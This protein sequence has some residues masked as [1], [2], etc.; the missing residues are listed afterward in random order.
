MVSCSSRET[1]SLKLKKKFPDFY[2][3]TADRM[4]LLSQ[5]PPCLN[6]RTI[7]LTERALGLVFLELLYSV[8]YFIISFLG[9]PYGLPGW[10]NKSVSRSTALTRIRI[11]TIYETNPDTEA[12]LYAIFFMYVNIREQCNLSSSFSSYRW[13]TM[14]EINYCAWGCAKASCLLTIN[15]Q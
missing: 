13:Q 9:R 11:K 7:P 12:E 8:L 14:F 5:S 6:G 1:V 10:E 15:P 4:S 2:F 3:I